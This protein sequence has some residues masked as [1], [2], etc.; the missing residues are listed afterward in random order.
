MFGASLPTVDAFVGLDDWEATLNPEDLN[1]GLAFD[2]SATAEVQ[3]QLGQGQAALVVGQEPVSSLLE[4]SSL[5]QATSGSSLGGPA[6]PWRSSSG[7]SGS[8]HSDSIGS[9]SIG[10]DII[11]SGSTRA[12][13]HDLEV[14]PDSSYPCPDCNKSW[15]NRPKFLFVSPPFF[16]PRVNPV[17]P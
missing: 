6:Q 12:A 7:S 11:G 10:S 4:S 1:G 13:A 14:E 8:I 16:A 17:N 3:I 9:G 15:D 5:S 2:S